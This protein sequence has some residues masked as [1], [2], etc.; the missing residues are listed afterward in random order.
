MKTE[1]RLQNRNKSRKKRGGSPVV[2]T[3][4]NDNNNELPVADVTAYI[5]PNFSATG[6]RILNIAP[7]LNDKNLPLAFQKDSEEYKKHLYT[8]F[9]RITELSKNNAYIEQSA[10]KLGMTVSTFNDKLDKV[11]KR[12][13]NFD[14][15]GPI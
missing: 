14:F 15:L 2:A 7:P 12:L 13:K 10:K 4:I 8:E 9:K 3:R 11:L 6:M 1:K 5:N